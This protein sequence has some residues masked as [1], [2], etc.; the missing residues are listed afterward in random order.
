MAS[1]FQRTQIFLQMIK[2]EHSIFALPFAY[3]GLF[4]AEG[5]LPR[6]E[7]FGWVTLAMVSFRT[8]GMS[9]NRLV[10]SQIDARNPR[11][12]DRALPAGKLTPRF[13][14]QVAGLSLFLFGWAAWQL[15]SLCFSLAWF[16][17]ALAVLYPFM[18]R[19]S[20][21]SHFVL[22]MILGIA[23]YG[24]WLAARP[25]FSW[26]PGLLTIG[27]TAWVAGF[28]MIYALQDESFDRE[29][30]LYSFPARFG[31]AATLTAVR[32]LHAVALISWAWAGLQSG[33]GA[34][35][36]AGL[37]MV[38]FF[39]IRENF[40]AGRGL[41]YIQEAFF[42]MNAVVSVALFLAVWADL[43]FRGGPVG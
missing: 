24:A 42:T 10:D 2:F 16:P 38:G 11:T 40:L 41:K 36:A 5:G 14:W 9:M 4:L 30:Q 13:V 34:V 17:A 19:F 35:Y 32:I 29:N 15:N 18:K 31:Q 39:L 27:V 26:I 37:L 21:F 33:L 22:G 3:L 6:L 8:F 23:P 20:W 12:R 7:V 1:F 43:S 28:D 25:E